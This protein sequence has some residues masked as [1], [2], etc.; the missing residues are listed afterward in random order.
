MHTFNR[1]WL[2]S[3]LYPFSLLFRLAVNVRNLLYDRAILRSDTLPVPI[4]SIGNL[5]V[6]GT[7]KTPAVEYFARWL[8]AHNVRPAIVTRGYGRQ[9]RGT[10]VVADGKKLCAN[11][12]ASGDEAMQLARRLPEAVV[13]ADDSK[14]RGARIACTTFPVDVVIIDDGFQHRRLNRDLDIVLIDAPSFFGNRWLL[15]AGPFR[16]PLTA[17]RRAAAVILTNIDGAAASQLDDLEARCRRRTTASLIRATLQPLSFENIAG[18]SLPLSAL[19]G[20]RVFAVCGIAQPARFLEDLRSVGAVVAERQ[21]FP[22]HHAFT[23]KEI[24]LLLKRAQAV[25][26]DAVVLT[27]K[28]ATKWSQVERGSPVPISFLRVEFTPAAAVAEVQS[29]LLALVAHRTVH[30]LVNSG[31]K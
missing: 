13:I 19:R 22:D 5:T 26:A 29:R 27:E 31:I 30:P 24:T 28:D 2:A 3:G 1:R 4:I 12:G 9:Q 8:L 11:V 18:G 15:P 16:E 17:L 7:G 14:A 25:A 23:E 10:V 6:G 20:K 21:L